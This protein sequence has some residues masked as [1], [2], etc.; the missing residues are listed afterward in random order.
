MRMPYFFLE[1]SLVQ[2]AAA[3]M[4]ELEQYILGKVCF[5]FRFIVDL[6]TFDFDV[7]KLAPPPDSLRA[8]DLFEENVEQV[9]LELVT[10]GRVGARYQMILVIPPVSITYSFF[11]LVP[12]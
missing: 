3:A 8:R 7:S 5:H 10:K 4:Q 9:K 6:G 12:F 2:K 11:D 1:E